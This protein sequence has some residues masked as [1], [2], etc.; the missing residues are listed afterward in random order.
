MINK[1][2]KFLW[3]ILGIRYYD[4]LKNQ[5]SQYL[6]DL[7]Y[8]KVGEGTYDNGAIVWR[9]AQSSQL[10]IGKYCSIAHGVQ[11]FLDGGFHDYNH[12]TTFPLFSE[13]YKDAGPHQKINGHLTKAHFF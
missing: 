8:C 2:R 9:W 3:K 7:P 10:E 13:L 11:F 1:V 6:S 4:F 12:V 5:K